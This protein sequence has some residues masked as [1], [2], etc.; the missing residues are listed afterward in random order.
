MK[1]RRLPRD[2]SSWPIETNFTLR[3]DVSFRRKAELGR[4]AEPAASVE[5]DPTATLAVHRG[6]GLMPGSAPIKVLA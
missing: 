6:N 4:A 1:L 3:P 2:V 5:D